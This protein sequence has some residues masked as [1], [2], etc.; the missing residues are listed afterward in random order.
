MLVGVGGVCRKSRLV[1][2]L[3]FPVGVHGGLVVGHDYDVV[4]DVI[5]TAYTL[6]MVAGE[7]ERVRRRTQGWWG[8]VDVLSWQGWW[9]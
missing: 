6:S 1:C 3:V 2:E 9:C 7:I 8:I 4:G 5:G